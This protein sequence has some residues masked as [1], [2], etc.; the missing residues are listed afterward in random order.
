[1][2]AAIIDLGSNSFRLLLGTYIDGQ[3]HNEPKRL[4]TTR[5]GKR[6][7]NGYLTEEAIQKGLDALRDIKEAV[8]AY[9]AEKVIGLATSAVR[10]APN[11]EEFMKDA[12]KICPMEGR[13]LTGEEEAYYGFHGAVGDYLGDEKHYALIDVGGG[14]TEL[15]LGDIH[16]VY[17]RR[18]YPVGAVSLQA[19]AEE[20]PQA[21]WE[22]TRFLWD[23]MPIAGPFGEYIGIGGTITTLAAI[24]LKLNAYNPMKVQGHRLTREAIEG[25]VM[26]LRYMTAEERSHVPGLPAGR[27]DIIVAGAEIVTS[28]MD[29]YDI[30]YLVVSDRNGME[31]MQAELVANKHV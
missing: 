25:M 2:K 30:G 13:I 11:G 9:G 23:P 14:S 26:E 20:G 19:I 3:W 22:E 16:E 10:E 15:A 31:G 1:M 5:L 28:F 6:D 12:V 18:S 24:H 27:A 29:A 4:W 7:A 21:V 17:W 8:Q